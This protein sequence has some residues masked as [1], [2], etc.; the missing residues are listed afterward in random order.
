M[1]LLFVFVGVYKAL[2]QVLVV[3]VSDVE[4]DTVIVGL[5]KTPMTQK[6]ESFRSRVLIIT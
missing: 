2:N 3:A 5:P 6:G 4:C 1:R